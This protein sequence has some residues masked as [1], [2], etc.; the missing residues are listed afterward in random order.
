MDTRNVSSYRLSKDIGVSDSLIG[1]YR[2]GKN[3]PSLENLV[4][5]ADYFEISV[6][7]LIGRSFP[8]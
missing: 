3:S 1:Y 4:K 5:I 2:M 7:K 8:N 6:D